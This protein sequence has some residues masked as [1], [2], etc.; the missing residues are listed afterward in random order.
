MYRA[1]NLFIKTAAAR[2]VP[3]REFVSGDAVRSTSRDAE[4]PSFPRAGRSRTTGWPVRLVTKVW[5]I[6]PYKV[7]SPYKVG[8]A[9]IKQLCKDLCTIL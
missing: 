2:A 6:S 8:C 5:C 9:R 3:E 7:V 4:A 1:C